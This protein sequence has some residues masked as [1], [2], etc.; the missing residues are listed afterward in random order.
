M[1]RLDEMAFTLLLERKDL[2]SFNEICIA[3]H[4]DVLGELL[5]AIV[6]L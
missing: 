1:V 4:L 5:S 3:P 2:T 6:A